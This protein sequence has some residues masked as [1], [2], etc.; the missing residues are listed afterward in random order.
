MPRGTHKKR[1][2][3]LVAPGAMGDGATG[4]KSV[5]ETFVADDSSHTPRGVA[6]PP[7]CGLPTRALPDGGGFCSRG[8]RGSEAQAR[9]HYGGAVQAVCVGGA[10]K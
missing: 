10:N 1:G 2:G 6:P 8:T 9:A 5:V 4:W 3:R 7:S